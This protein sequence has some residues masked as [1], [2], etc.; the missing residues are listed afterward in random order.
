MAVG[1]WSKSFNWYQHYSP[2]NLERIMF[3]QGT[4]RRIQSPPPLSW[5]L[6]CTLD[7]LI[8]DFAGCFMAGQACVA[9]SWAKSMAG[10]QIRK[11]T[12]KA[13]LLPILEWIDSIK[14]YR[15]RRLPTFS[16]WSGFGVLSTVGSSRLTRHVSECIFHLLS[17]THAGRRSAMARS[18][19][20]TNG[21]G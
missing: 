6:T 18:T 3:H 21:N 8:C 5:A 16:E 19:K 7:G 15:M 14:P 2:T 13:V 17:L 1:A 9:P 10:M 4:C 12:T 20:K 11:F